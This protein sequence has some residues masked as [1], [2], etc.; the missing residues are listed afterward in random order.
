MVI[1]WIIRTC[2]WIKAI[3][4]FQLTDDV[5]TLFSHPLFLADVF[6]S[7]PLYTVNEYGNVTI[8]ELV[9]VLMFGTYI[10]AKADLASN[11]CVILV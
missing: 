3:S 6:S 7:H 2:P 11:T 8:D 10:K 4:N 5:Y 9:K 1:R